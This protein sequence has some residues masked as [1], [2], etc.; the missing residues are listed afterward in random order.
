[1]QTKEASVKRHCICSRNCNSVGKALRT[2]SFDR[3]CRGSVRE[4][5]TVL[6]AYPVLCDYLVTYIGSQVLYCP[7][8]TEWFKL[9]TLSA[10]SVRGVTQVQQGRKVTLL[11]HSERDYG[12]KY[13]VVPVPRRLVRVPWGKKRGELT[14]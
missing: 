2:V 8:A 11:I 7:T 13:G 1:M 12:T 5:A 10:R 3:N 6:Q 4:Y 9:R 14:K